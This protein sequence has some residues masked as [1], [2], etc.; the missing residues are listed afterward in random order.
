[1]RLYSLAKSK[2]KTKKFPSRGK[3]LGIG[4]TTSI[5]ITIGYFVYLS[6]I[7]VN[8]DFPILGSAAREVSSR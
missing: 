1:M 5:V 6:M 7:P 2:Q 4:V 3:I 8:A